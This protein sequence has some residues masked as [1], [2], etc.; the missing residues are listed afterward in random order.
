MGV[1]FAR[2]Q[3]DGGE[4]IF[5]ENFHVVLSAHDDKFELYYALF[6]LNL[7]WADVRLIFVRK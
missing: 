5:R 7:F 1:I 3:S 6:Y 4:P 2:S